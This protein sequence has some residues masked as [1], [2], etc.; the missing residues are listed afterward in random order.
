MKNKIFSKSLYVEGLK[1]SRSI[2][3]PFLAVVL[4]IGFITVSVSADSVSVNAWPAL[5]SIYTAIPLMTLTLFHFLNTRAGSDYYHSIPVSRTNLITSYGAAV[6]TWAMVPVLIY[7]AILLAFSLLCGIRFDWHTCGEMLTISFVCGFVMLSSLLLSMSISSTVVGQIAIAGLILFLPRSLMDVFVSTVSESLPILA[8]SSG[9]FGRFFSS[10]LN[11][12]YC[13]SPFSILFGHTISEINATN[14]LYTLALGLVLFIAAIVVFNRRRSE[15]ALSSAPNVVVQTTVRIMIALMFC[16]VPFYSIADELNFGLSDILTSENIAWYGF[17]LIAYFVYEIIS[18]RG[19]RGVVRTWRSM[20]VGLVV[21]LALNVAF[22]AGSGTVARAV[23]SQ[24]PEAEEITGISIYYEM[25]DYYSSYENIKARNVVVE[26]EEL[27]EIAAQELSENIEYLEN[28]GSRYD[29]NSRYPFSMTLYLEDGSELVRNIYFDAD[30]YDELGRL[31]MNND[32]LM[33]ICGSYPSLDEITEINCGVLDRSDPDAAMEL[34]KS[35]IKEAEKFNG[36]PWA[37]TEA[38]YPNG[39]IL[40]TRSSENTGLY[41]FCSIDVYGTVNG[42]PFYSIYHVMLDTPKTAQLYADSCNEASG[43]PFEQALGEAC[44][45][46]WAD[47]TIDGGN[48]RDAEGNYIYTN[49]RYYY[50]ENG[51][52][53][54]SIYSG[55]EEQWEKL[56]AELIENS[57]KPVDITKPFFKVV[58]SVYGE[59]EVKDYTYFIQANEENSVMLDWDIYY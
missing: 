26:D 22:I 19:V 58:I 25:D 31:L 48:L 15:T 41:D 18:Q 8:D 45:A 51:E 28:V 21:L 17:G 2:G 10:D 46:R 5:L 38:L 3:L 9:V 27:F 52:A 40:E 7:A 30:A 33:E 42:V 47:I 44:S 12:M 50:V 55:G 11:L 36:E 34:Y 6:Y 59:D 29:F 49:T 16:L 56:N 20:I 35:Y 39:N 1:Q 57:R 4:L 54:I 37:F 43:V 14:T 32:E 13:Y 23:L 53:D 24:Q